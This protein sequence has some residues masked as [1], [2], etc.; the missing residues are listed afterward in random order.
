MDEKMWIAYIKD[1]KVLLIKDLN[2]LRYTEDL[3][4]VCSP[5]LGCWMYFVYR[6]PVRG[7]LS[8]IEL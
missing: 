7:L 6:G 4:E 3:Y 5:K 1:L 8:T 2:F